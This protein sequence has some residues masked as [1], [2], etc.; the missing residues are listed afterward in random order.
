MSDWIDGSIKPTKIGIY[1]RYYDGDIW[2]CKWDGQTWFTGV[3]NVYIAK[4]EK[5]ISRCQNLPWREIEEEPK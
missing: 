1:E 2:C 4:N 5:M 3:D